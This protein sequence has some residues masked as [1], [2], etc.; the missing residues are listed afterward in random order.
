M[1]TSNGQLPTAKAL[2]TANCQDSQLPI[3]R[4]SYSFC[5]GIDRGKW[6]LR[7]PWQVVFGNGLEVGS[8]EWLGSWQ[9][10]VGS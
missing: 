7:V 6:Q 2:P 1:T 10:E 8:W 3:S 5:V 9:L 4:V